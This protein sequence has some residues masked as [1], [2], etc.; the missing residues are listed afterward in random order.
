MREYSKQLQIQSTLAFQ[1]MQL[2]KI[3]NLYFLG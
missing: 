3:D 2:L 1:S